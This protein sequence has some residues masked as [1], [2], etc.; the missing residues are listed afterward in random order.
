MKKLIKLADRLDLFGNSSIANSI[1]ELIVKASKIEK[2][3]P[4]SFP[5]DNKKKE[6]SESKK[7]DKKGES[8]EEILKSVSDK[9][10]EKE[11]STQ[12]NYNTEEKDLVSL[13][14]LLK[15][16]NKN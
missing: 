5:I 4:S 11:E 12:R 10:S 16:Y 1:D 2:I 15:L 14:E 13:E 6:N 8:F 3:S 7:E 9:I